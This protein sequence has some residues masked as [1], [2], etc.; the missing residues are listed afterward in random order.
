MPLS[1]V[2]G[3]LPTGMCS[4]CDWACKATRAGRWEDKGGG[5]EG[6][7]LQ[8]RGWLGLHT[9]HSPS[10][11]VLAALAMVAP[12]LHQSGTLSRNRLEGCKHESRHLRASTQSNFSRA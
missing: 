7:M 1:S 6:A 5:V 11:H 10:H 2:P 12:L 9:S 8:G 4:L 3:A